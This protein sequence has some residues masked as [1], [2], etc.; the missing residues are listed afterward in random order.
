MV[1]EIVRDPLFLARPSLPA[2]PEDAGI[3]RD[4]CETLLHWRQSCVGM[5]AN[6]IGTDKRI[7]LFA[8]QGG[9]SV[10]LNAEIVKGSG[11]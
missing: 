1:R 6:R 2:G 8:D 5:A 4:L 9:V 10:M 7:I 11:A 3:G